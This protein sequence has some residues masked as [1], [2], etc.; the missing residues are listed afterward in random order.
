MATRVTLA[1]PPL[2]KGRSPSPAF[3]PARRVGINPRAIRDPHPVVATFADAPA[4]PTD[5][6][7]FKG[8]YG[9][10]GFSSC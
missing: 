1:P 6:S 9:A 8:R 5:L 7:F 2:E 4:A 10:S 3:K